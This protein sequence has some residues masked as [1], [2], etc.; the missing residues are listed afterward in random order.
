MV[1]RYSRRQDVPR[2]RRDS[3][4]SSTSLE[5]SSSRNTTQRGQS[6][7]RDPSRE[8]RQ[9]RTTRVPANELSIDYNP[10]GRSSRVYHPPGGHGTRDTSRDYQPTH[11]QDFAHSSET[12]TNPLV[13][14]FD[15]LSI[16]NDSHY[17][18]SSSAPANSG[19]WSPP[20][21]STG[22]EVL[23]YDQND[24][25]SPQS[26]RVAS[27]YYPPSHN[28][29]SQPPNFAQPGYAVPAQSPTKQNATTT[30]QRPQ[31]NRHV[32]GTRGDS[33]T[34]DKTYFIRKNDYKKFFRIG[35]VFSTLWTDA[36]GGN[37]DS[38]DQ[39][40][41]S[42][43]IYKER[44]FSKVRR[45]IIVREG[46]RSVTCLPVTSYNGVGPLKSGIQLSDHG[47]IYSKAPP[48]RIEGMQTRPLKL[49]LA[50]GAQ[51]LRD[52][53]LVNYA[54]VYTVETN[55]KVK[56]VGELD[57]ESRRILRRYFRKVFSDIESDFD[58]AE[59]TPRASAA[60]LVGVGGGVEGY[61]V[62]VPPAPQGMSSYSTATFASDPA[63]SGYPPPNQYPASGYSGYSANTTP[64]LGQ[65]VQRASSVGYPYPPSNSVYSATQRFD[66]TAYP[67]GQ[68]HQSFSYPN[69]D[70]SSSQPPSSAGGSFTAPPYTVSYAQGRS[71]AGQ[72]YGSQGYSPDDHYQQ[73]ST[74]NPA[75][76]AS[77]THASTVSYP[78]YSSQDQYSAS[79]AYSETAIGEEDDIVLPTLQ[80]AQQLN[81]HRRRRGSKSDG[82]RKDRKRYS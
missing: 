29:D 43:V 68:S 79:S 57:S 81:E 66:S 44:V 56:D 27:A 23:S 50:K 76:I 32:T 69:Q 22:H 40:F 78:D 16:S 12:T 24:L 72:P 35:R 64:G 49:N 55:V 62:P 6:R 21:T 74:T 67:A 31:P 25:P 48:E 52:L 61:P 41:V 7:I 15:T 1:V 47:F 33:E 13:G 10:Q 37:A 54:K 39:T 45:F 8:E 75:H 80:S 19:L 5:A 20:T 60:S 38:V 34:I 30:K 18:V 26:A 58:V 59:A 73:H 42:E 17:T 65:S 63:A 46:D 71:A 14:R 11:P 3:V 2:N 70:P 36:L 77:S 82:K 28:Y 53:S 9:D 51:N 4:I